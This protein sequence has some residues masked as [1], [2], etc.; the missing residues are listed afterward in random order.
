MNQKELE[1]RYK[2][3]VKFWYEKFTGLSTEIDQ[4][5]TELERQRKKVEKLVCE[6]FE[7]LKEL[8]RIKQQ[9]EKMEFS[10][11]ELEK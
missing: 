6:N 7:V 1:I 2:A 9:S 4:L 10:N 5:H 8:E 3:K 11:I